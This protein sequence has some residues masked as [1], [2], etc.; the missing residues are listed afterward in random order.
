VRSPLSLRAR[1][2][3]FFIGIVVVPLVVAGLVVERLAV[4]QADART[5]S[6]L[7]TAV[8]GLRTAVLDRQDRAATVTGLV[9]AQ[10]VADAEGGLGLDER[11]TEA[12]L[13]YLLVVRSGEVLAVSM[14]P[15]GFLPGV[16]VR[17]Q[18][19]AGPNP[20]AGLV[21]GARVEIEARAGI[22]VRGGFFLDRPFLE[23]LPVLAASVS[24]GE[25]V[26]SPVQPPPRVNLE[27]T[28]PFDAGPNLR[29]L[30]VPFEN[31]PG[32]GLVALVRKP[33]GGALSGASGAIL[34]LLGVGVVIASGLG[35]GLARLIARPLQRLAEGALAVAGGDLDQSVPATGDDDVARLG[36][37]FNTMTANLRDSIGELTH[38]RDELRHGL[39]RLGATLSAS[40]DVDGLLAVVLETAAGTLGAEAGA[41]YLRLPR[42][43]EIASRAVVGVRGPI[44]LRV[45]EGLAGYAAAEAQA[46]RVGPEGRLAPE[47]PAAETALAVPLSRGEEIYGVLALYGRAGG[48][49]FSDDDLVTLASLAAQAAVAIENVHLQREAERLA[50]TDALTGVWNRRY[51][52]ETMGHELDRAGR[53]GRT[54]SLLLL[55][56]DHFKEVND[57]YGHVRGDLVLVELSRRIQDSI[58]ANI[59]VLARYGG[60]EFVILLPETGL[61]GGLA[62]AEKVRAVVHDAPFGANGDAIALTVS[63]GVA[64]YPAD[65]R[66][67]DDLLRAADRALYRAKRA[68]RDRVMAAARDEQ[69]PLT[70]QP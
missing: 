58:R 32:S 51:L 36:A 23:A 29:G 43:Q 37:A 49:A 55:D 38:S 60:E 21:A 4:R 39:D 65:G 66:D 7:D 42:R 33:S 30:F 11:R 56:L 6:T 45:G 17:A 24:R 9:A 27:A 20:P 61:Q 54:V 69:Q 26:A 67:A 64:T 10:A 63:V 1:L 62:A 13:D 28:G 53:Y 59:D 25:V 47:E 52:Q 31:E 41:A 3:L 57:R 8:P 12:G 2:T 35:Y 34:L 16:P 18:D 68:G 70:E 22:E 44:R 5:D 48:R 50:V 46:L 40:H 14:R 15:K 19:L